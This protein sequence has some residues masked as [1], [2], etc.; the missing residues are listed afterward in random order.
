LVTSTSPCK[1]SK[2]FKNF[3]IKLPES[4]AIIWKKR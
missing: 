1:T 4:I 2:N 3:K